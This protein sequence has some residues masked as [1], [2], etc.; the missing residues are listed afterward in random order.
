MKQIFKLSLLALIIF[1]INSC[2][3][4]DYDESSYLLKE[5]VFTDFDRSKQFLTGIY[6][7]LP[8]GFDPIDG[9]MRSSASDDAVHVWDNS[10]IQKFND[11][12]FGLEKNY[13]H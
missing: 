8:A 7:Y 1:G 11:V 9:A 6:G 3:Y 13:I 4:L 10:E 12:V 2:E 5:N